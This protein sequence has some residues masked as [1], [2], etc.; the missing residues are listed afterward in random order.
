MDQG[1]SIKESTGPHTQ[2]ILICSLRHEA[3]LDLLLDRMAEIE[4]PDPRL[5]ICLIA[6]AKHNCI[7]A[8]RIL[9]ARGVENPLQ[10]ASGAGNLEIVRF[11]L[12]AG[13][14]PPDDHTTSNT[15]R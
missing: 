11:L 13:P 9:L 7:G 4:T 2:D 3:V 12:D 15:H 6:A 14:T 8:V 1:A 5:S 10:K